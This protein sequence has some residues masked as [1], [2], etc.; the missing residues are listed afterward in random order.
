M[1]EWL[2]GRSQSRRTASELY[3][4]VVA[5]ARQPLFYT[6]LGVPDTPEGRYELVVIALFLVLERLRAEGAERE[7]L[8]QQV[9]E[10]FVTDMDDCMRE[11]G[12][13]D[14]TVPKRVK[15]AAAGFYERAAAYRAALAGPSM[16]GL[17]EALL[18]YV[19]NGA[20]AAGHTRT[21]ATFV[22]S[23]S[24]RLLRMSVRDLVSGIPQIFDMRVLRESER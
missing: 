1:L 10:A 11:M 19:Y 4:R 2:T 16:D 18:T 14:L 13:G 3:G 7:K 17:G 21:L 20:T 15:R 8:S 5:E 9:L 24:E 6:D 23:S 22:R 12:V